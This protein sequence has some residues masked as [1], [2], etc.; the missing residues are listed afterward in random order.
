[1]VNRR[2]YQL[3]REYLDYLTQV[4]QLDPRSVERYWF[5]LRH[6]L[7][8]ADEI[9][10]GRIAS[11]RPGF[12][13]FLSKVH[14]DCGDEGFAPS[15]SKKI[16]QTVKRFLIWSKMN[17]PAELR[18]SPLKGIPTPRLQSASADFVR[19]SRGISFSGKP[20]IRRRS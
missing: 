1:M 11:I 6:L 10:P 3:V 13:F 17:S 8:W 18:K 14:A 15:T 2:N 7:L 5:Y 9:L 12:P 16:I 4:S 20:P 19:F